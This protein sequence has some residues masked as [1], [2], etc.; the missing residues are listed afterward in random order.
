MCG[1]LWGMANCEYQILF[2]QALSPHVRIT[3]EDSI[4]YR[5]PE[6]PNLLKGNPLQPENSQEDGPQQLG[7]SEH[8]LVHVGAPGRFPKSLYST[9]SASTRSRPQAC[10]HV[11]EQAL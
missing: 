4:H 8:A 11:R 10:D 2:F 6:K 3:F 9:D 1:A 7:I 5:L